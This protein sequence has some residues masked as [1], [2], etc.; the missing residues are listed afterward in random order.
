MKW[1][2]ATFI[3]A[4]T[5]PF[6]L[7][8]ARKKV[9]PVRPTLLGQLQYFHLPVVVQIH[10]PQ[11]ATR[12]PARLPA[13][14][15]RPYDRLVLSLIG[16]DLSGKRSNRLI[17]SFKGSTEHVPKR[18]PLLWIG[19]RSNGINRLKG[20][21]ESVMETIALVPL[22]RTTEGHWQIDQSRAVWSEPTPEI[23]A[24]RK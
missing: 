3:G 21:T 24:T 16:L 6:A 4:R 11:C 13:Y 18:T 5:L 10:G 19:V 1:V 12:R 8:I 9:Q 15:R 23:E 7:R 14:A 22:Q 17:A 20:R 2:F